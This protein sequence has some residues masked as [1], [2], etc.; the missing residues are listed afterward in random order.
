MSLPQI[1]LETVLKDAA[2]NTAMSSYLKNVDQMAKQTD[3]TA[4]SIGGRFLALGGVVTKFAAMTATAIA[5]VATG[6]VIGFGKAAW[7]AGQRF[8]GAYDAIAIAT[9]AAGEELEG[10]SAAFDDVFK[11]VPV[12]DMDK[13]AGVLSLFDQRAGATDETLSGLTAQMLEAARI[14]KGDAIPMTESFSR[15]MGDW[16]ISADE[17]SGA[18]DMFFRAGQESGVAM[19][20]LMA[21]VVQ[22]GSP[23]RLMGFSL[24]EATALFGQFGAQGVNAELVMG[25]LR[26]AA[27]KFAKDGVPL[28]EG[29]RDTM[30]AIRDTTD[31]SAALALGMEVFGA[32]A[33][34]DMTAAIREGRFEIDDLVAT[35]SEA[36]GAIM[37]TAA[38]TM[39][40][41]EK[42]QVWRQRI[43]TGLKPIGLTMMDIA[44]KLAD[45]FLPIFEQKI[46]PF[47]EE[48]VV[49]A[50]EAVAESIAMLLEGD[51]S[52]ALS[53]L[54]GPET[55]TKIL[56]VAGAVQAFI[57]RVI[58][59]V[60][61]H[62]E[63]FRIALIAIGAVLAAAAIASAV[64]GIA[65]A[66]AALANPVTLVIAAV[67]L[68]A[69]AWTQDWGGIRTTLT[70]FWNDTLKPFIDQL[71]TWFQENVPQ[72][73]AAVR[74]WFVTAWANIQEA[75]QT[76]WTALQAVWAALVN[77]FT[78]VIPGA[79]TA[80]WQGIQ[81]A[82]TAIG[83]AFT[84]AW[85]AILTF[86][87]NVWDT[88]RVV[89][90]TAIIL[91][92]QLLGTNLQE[93][94]A[95]W[96]F[97][98][99]AIRDFAAGVWEAIKTTVTT[100]FNAVKSFIE[101]TLATL[102]TNWETA[103]NLVSGI[104]K[105][106]WDAIYAKVSAVAEA[107][108][109]YV[110][111]K[112]NTLK[113]N[114]ETAWGL[115]RDKAGEI[116]DAIK[117]KVEEILPAIIG[118]V[119]AKAA[120]LKASFI[121]PIIAAKDAVVGMVGEWV[122]LG[123]D[124][125]GGFVSGV[126]EKAN[127]LVNAVK[128]AVGDAVQQAKNLLGIHSPSKIGAR[129]IGAPFAAGIGV[130]FEEMMAKLTRV[131]LPRMMAQLTAP[132]MTR[133][134]ERLYAPASIAIPRGGNS[135][136]VSNSYRFDLTAQYRYQDERSLTD[137]VR[138]LQMMAGA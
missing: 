82:L 98:W 35:L 77:V 11:S 126:V 83:T 45:K 134:A 92:L 79:A 76:V 68:L 53:N 124:L 127:S 10:L 94:K 131:D 89:V 27:G 69:A 59:F 80:L 50:F 46:V 28:Q 121:D 58:A 64:A 85:N 1:G 117:A 135:T 36:D 136:T 38:A 122:Q 123:R 137:D 48:K 112:V 52:G 128:G 62:A 5:A 70:A 61:E 78:V 109:G 91:V 43:Q 81:N 88:I 34:P 12:D 23:M 67:G 24:E 16:G 60:T 93:I 115:I 63:A 15:A 22:F 116:W 97:M 133:P 111:E 114:W 99:S 30:A 96:D 56:E 119:T 110:E 132:A 130:G 108:R 74:D 39:D 4:G 72:A 65:G 75:V 3:L 42:V 107:I 104:A 37:D 19:D 44:G 55:A 113:T 71:V 14:T 100:V 31:E 6:A 90:L 51:V 29:L 41:G 47:L 49:P 33:G 125:I 25:S 40:W 101:T 120:E 17:A 20:S 84:E 7:D 26:I 103:W 102:R 106:V 73:L 57:D 86:L 9:G 66:I 18:M 2:F 95:G 118:V 13:A 32:R 129:E 8:D 87:Q 54:V 21:S 138:L 105:T